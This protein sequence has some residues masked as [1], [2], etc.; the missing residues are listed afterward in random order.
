MKSSKSK[1]GLKPLLEQGLS[2]SEFCGDGF[3]CNFQN[4]SS[5]EY[6]DQLNEIILC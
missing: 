4:A 5:A 1:V 3:D 2:E 6:F